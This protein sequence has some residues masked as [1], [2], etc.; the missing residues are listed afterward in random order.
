[1]RRLTIAIVSA[2]FVG[3]S[4]ALTTATLTILLRYPIAS[5]YTQDLQVIELAAS[6]MLIAALFQFSDAIQ[7]ISACIL[8]GFKDTKAMF[9]ITFVSYWL[10]GLPVGCV[11]ALTD[12]WVSPMQAKGFWV[13]FI[14]GLTT[15]AILL[16]FR[17]YKIQRNYSSTETVQ[18]AVT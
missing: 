17:V 14:V 1:M 8:R 11:L 3:I 16:G 10:V 13:G 18:H 4:I 9:Y 12:W 2:L 5:L 15:A 7:V 6:L